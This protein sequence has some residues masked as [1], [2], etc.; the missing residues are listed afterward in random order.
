ME[1]R[2]SRNA[3]FMTFGAGLLV[4]LVMAFFWPFGHTVPAAAAEAEKAETAH[5]QVSAF[6]YAGTAGGPKLLEPSSGAYIVDTQ[7]GRVWRIVGEGKP[8]LLGKAE[9]K[10]E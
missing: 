4:G 10:A 6:G 5:F 3:W 9:G 7:D 2:M 1:R 8:K